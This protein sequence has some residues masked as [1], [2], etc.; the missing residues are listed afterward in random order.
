METLG[1]SSQEIIG[2][3]SNNN[4]YSKDGTL[5]IKAFETITADHVKLLEKNHITIRRND[6]K[7]SESELSPNKHA[8]IIDETVKEIRD[9]FQDIRENKKIPLVK[10]R[11]QIVPILH[12]TN[13]SYEVLQLFTALQ[14]KDDYTYR[15]NIAVGAISNLIGTWM[16]LPKQEI[17]QLTTAGLLHD[18]GKM[19]VPEE[20]LNKPGRLNEEEFEE[21]KS[22][23]VYGYEILKDTVGIGHRQALVALQHHE[24]MDGSG[25][26]LQLKRGEI[27][28]F[29]RI[30]AVADVFHA[31]SSNRVYQ[32]RS[33]LYEVLAEMEREMFAK[34]DPEITYL[35]IE[36][37]MY[38][39]IGSEVLLTDGRKGTIVLVPSNEPTKPLLHVENEFVNL[40]TK[41]NVKIDQIIS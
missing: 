35:F 3:K 17:L 20:I 34:L 27:D 23:T 29:S 31:M 33:P 28:L 2:K 30:V 6:V 4:V 11:E 39:L 24:R 18:V 21:M 1:E 15:H 5:L 22:H 37:T 36:Q 16:K 25:Y 40:R 32:E 38:S 41:D 8:Q 14:A 10:I 26:P 13:E 12:D 19:L 7:E 9:I